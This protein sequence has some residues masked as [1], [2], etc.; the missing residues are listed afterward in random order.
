GEADC[1]ICVYSAA[2]ALDLAFVPVGQERYE[3]AI[4]REQLPDARIRALVAALRS[5]AFRERLTAMGG[6]D[7]TL[8]GVQRGLP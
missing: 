1:G 5:P 4:R 7:T 6:Y 2:K 3:L 8:T